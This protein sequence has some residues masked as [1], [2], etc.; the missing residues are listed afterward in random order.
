MKKKL[1]YIVTILTLVTTGCSLQLPFNPAQTETVTPI[2]SA[3]PTLTLTPTLVPTPTLT[4]MPA[5]RV[6]DADYALFLGDYDQAMQL[7]QDTQNASSDTEIQAAALYGIGRVQ[8]LQ[9]NA[10]QALDTF[11]KIVGQYASL[12]EGGWSFFF[13]GQIYS[14]LKRYDDAAAA[15]A[16]YLQARP[17]MIDSYVQELRG[18]ALANGG[19]YAEAITAY[20]AAAEAPHLG[21]NQSMEIAEANSKGL[22]GDLP[23]AIEIYS[24]IYD[25][26]T[27][28]Y[29]KSQMDDLIGQADLALGETQE[30]YLRFQDAVNNFPSSYYS[31]QSLVTLVN[32]NVP[33]DDLNRGLVDYFAGQNDVAL[34]ALNRYLADPSSTDTGTAH[35]YKG[36]TLQ[37]IGANLSGQDALL[38]DQQAIAEWQNV[39]KI[40]RPATIG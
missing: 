14:S 24:G 19:R 4:P 39:I 3:T 22:N 30:G 32:A 38:E 35:Y 34:L 21:D 31:Y 6:Q 17:G 29:T 5:K 40:T 1:I 18:D 37:S 25:S 11:E 28:D 33:V 10:T 9:G 16:Q 23:G 26:S 12:P 15:Y 7:Y 27:N 2:P 8:W 20:L 36:L 13:L